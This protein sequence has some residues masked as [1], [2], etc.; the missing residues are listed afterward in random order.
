MHRVALLWCFVFI[1]ICCQKYEPFETR[2]YLIFGE[3]WDQCAGD[4]VRMYRL[5]HYSIR[6]D[7][8]QRLDTA[9]SIRFEDFGL[10]P[11]IR[12]SAEHLWDEM[13]LFLLA[14]ACGDIGEP[15]PKRAGAIYLQICRSGKINHWIIGRDLKRLPLF[16]HRY[17]NSV[18]QVLEALNNM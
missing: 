1:Q 3:F 10:D 9:E 18:L 6:I 2:D 15:D 7:Q 17:V 14:S 13:P 4:C 5:D 12:S 8:E 11:N 16:M